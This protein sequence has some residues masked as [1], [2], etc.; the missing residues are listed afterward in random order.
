MPGPVLLGQYLGFLVDGGQSSD[1]LE[2]SGQKLIGPFC[3]TAEANDLHSWLTVDWHLD[4]YR[5][6]GK[7]L[8]IRHSG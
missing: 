1:Y 6:H 5:S 8:G 4:E 3:T 7:S 2:S